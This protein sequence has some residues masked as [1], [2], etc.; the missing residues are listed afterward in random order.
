M[1]FNVTTS[2]RNCT[3]SAENYD[4]RLSRIDIANTLREQVQD[5]FNKKY[6]ELQAGVRWGGNRAAP[7]LL[8]R[9]V[10]LYFRYFFS[11]LFFP[12]NYLFIVCMGVCGGVH[13]P[14]STNVV[15][16]LGGIGCFVL[17]CGGP[18]NQTQSATLGGSH[19]CVRCPLTSSHPF[20]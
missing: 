6:G 13:I 1:P 7:C 4:T 5:L 17:L 2:V 3:H 12:F 15:I 16:R 18:G 20:P 9:E 11:L 14:P 10:D 19:L 8:G